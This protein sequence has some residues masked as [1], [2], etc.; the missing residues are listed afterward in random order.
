MKELPIKIQLVCYN[1]FNQ[2]LLV[3]RSPEDG[4]FWQMITETLEPNESI[5]E[6]QIRALAEEVGIIDSSLYTVEDELYRFSW[7]KDNFPVVEFVFPVLAK[8]EEV[9]LSE[10]HTEYT[11]VSLDRGIE[12]IK[13]ESSK[14]I[15]EKMKAYLAEKK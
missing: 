11:W 4:G 13:H 1:K 10:E 9:S 12:I 8:F 14:L 6:A 7:V 3:K 15:L 2:V 5:F